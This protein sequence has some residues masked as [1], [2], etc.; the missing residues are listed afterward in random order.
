MPGLPPPVLPGGKQQQFPS[1]AGSVWD[2]LPGF[3][4]LQALKVFVG[5]LSDWHMWAS[6]GWIALGLILLFTGLALW[7]RLPQRAVTVAETAARVA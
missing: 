5:E 4:A 3:S 7:A 6:L 2:W 1:P